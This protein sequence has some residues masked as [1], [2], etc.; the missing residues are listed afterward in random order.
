MQLIQIFGCKLVDGVDC[1]VPIISLNWCIFLFQV[2]GLDIC[3]LAKDFKG[4]RKESVMKTMM[5]QDDL[6]ET[7]KEILVVLGIPIS[8]KNPRKLNLACKITNFVDK[9]CPLSCIVNVKPQ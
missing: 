3:S 1:V 2:C 4:T 8:S 5:Y 6:Y 9:N 7:L